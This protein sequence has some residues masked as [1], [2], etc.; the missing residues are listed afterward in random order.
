MEEIQE[1]KAVWVALTNTDLTEGRGYQYP[2]AVCTS[3]ATAIRLGRKGSVMGTDCTVKKKI[4]VMID[5]SWLIPG[6]IKT[7]TKEDDIAQKKIDE[8][9]QLVSR[10]KEAGFT[11]DDIKK[12]K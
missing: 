4:A 2:L 10:M 11:E 6:R 8:K 12:L 5:N 1:V 3:E 7:N 9:E